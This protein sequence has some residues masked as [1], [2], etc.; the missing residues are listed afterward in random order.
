LNKQYRH[1]DYII[2]VEATNLHGRTITA[3]HK[4]EDDI[5]LSWYA[6]SEQYAIQRLFGLVVAIIDL[7][8][9]AYIP[10]VVKTLPAL[11]QKKFQEAIEG[12]EFTMSKHTFK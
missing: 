9:P 3:R 4:D 12:I 2:Q 5:C 6:G 11:K 10:Y 1:R 8:F 7:D